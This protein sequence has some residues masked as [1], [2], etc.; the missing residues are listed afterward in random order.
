M[1]TQP[2]YNFDS[3]AARPQVCPRCGGRVDPQSNLLRHAPSC[4]EL[5]KHG[6][7]NTSGLIPCGVAVL[8]LP[9]ELEINS[10]TIIIPE[11]VRERT[12]VVETRGIVIANGEN[13]V[14]DPKP[15]WNQQR[16]RAQPG[17]KVMLVRYAGVMIVGPA[18][19]RQ[20]RLVN[21]G[22]IYAKI[23]KEEELTDG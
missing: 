18:D 21:N 16:P 13:L 20:Y 2:K 3:P 8:I 15:E 1:M 23:S 12:V 14:P 17:D 6:I 10:S 5:G 19:Q 7:A 22:D 11:N 4:P 9:Y